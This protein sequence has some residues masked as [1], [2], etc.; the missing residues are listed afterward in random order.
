[1]AKSQSFNCSKRVLWV[2]AAASL[3][4]AQAPQLLGQSRPDLTISLTSVTSPVAPGG[5]VTIAYRVA[6]GGKAQA[7]ENGIKF[8]LSSD[9]SLNTSVDRY[10]GPSASAPQL[11]AG[12]AATDSVSRTIP[13]DVAGGS[14]YVIGWVDAFQ[15][16][17]E[18]SDTNNTASRALTVSAGTAP[19]AFTLT[20]PTADQVFASSTTSV[21]LS[22]AAASGAAQYEVY[23]GESASPSKVATQASRTLSRSVVA[24]RTY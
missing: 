9:T 14:W 3:V 17:T 2:V 24:G 13:A 18:T 1:M 15:A 19:G 5:S 4:G 7:P 22:W 11:A 12:S 10:L 23:F 16:V 8:Y 6:N 21:T 20:S